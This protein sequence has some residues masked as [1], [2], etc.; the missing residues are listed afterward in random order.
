MGMPIFAGLL[1]GVALAGATPSATDSAKGPMPP[2]TRAALAVFQNDWV[3]M[4]WALRFFDLDGDIALSPSEAAAAAAAFRKLADKDG[5]GRITPAEYRAAR[6]F[7]MT[8]Y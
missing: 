6:H 8:R 7:I 1:I 2:Q 5:D 4:N 3:L